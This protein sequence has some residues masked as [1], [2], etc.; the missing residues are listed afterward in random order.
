MGSKFY[1]IQVLLASLLFEHK[2]EQT[3]QAPGEE[4]HAQGQDEA[5][6]KLDE[7]PQLLEALHDRDLLTAR[8]VCAQLFG[9]DRLQRSD[10]AEEPIARRRLDSTG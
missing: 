4:D 7:F 6:K 9:I 10:A 8:S 2:R 3:P 5:V 1:E